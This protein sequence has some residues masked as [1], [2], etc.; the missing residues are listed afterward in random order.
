[1]CAHQGIRT[2]DF[3]YAHTLLIPTTE[4]IPFIIGV[5]NTYKHLVVAASTQVFFAL[6][7]F[8]KTDR[9][10][11]LKRL[12][13][14]VALL[15]FILIELYVDGAVNIVCYDKFSDFRADIVHVT[16]FL[17]LYQ[18]QV[19]WTQYTLPSKFFLNL[20][21]TFCIFKKQK[22]AKNHN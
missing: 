8:H 6:I 14:S 7:F 15:D 1:V 2:Q 21:N 11:N 12:V 19:F 5:G 10:T 4:R 17:C 13:A 16:P 22:R 18:L 9:I 20:F 3:F